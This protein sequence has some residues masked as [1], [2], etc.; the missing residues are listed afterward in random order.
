MN[1]YSLNNNQFGTHKIVAENIG[2]N[3]DVLDVGCNGGYLKKLVPNNV[4]YGID[5]DEDSL[6]AAK[7]E[8]YQEVFKLDLNNYADFIADRKFDLIIFADVLEHLLLPEEVL[9]FFR[10]HYLKEQG[11]IIISLPNIANISVRGQLLFGN[12][13]YV[14]NGILDRTHLH[15]YTL[16]TARNFIAAAGLKIDKERF[17]SNHF[18]RLIK[19]L[20]FL[21]GILAYNLIFICRKN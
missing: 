10:Q 6:V 1:N 3:R 2:I 12:F 7:K 16:K 18:G 5:Y 13:N 9:I 19:I 11:R 21:S 17:S 4:F 15:L 8:G 20:P 14:D